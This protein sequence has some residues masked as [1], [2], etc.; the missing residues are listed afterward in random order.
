M[1]ETTTT[2]VVV[3]ADTEAIANTRSIEVESIQA[4]THDTNTEEEKEEIR[5]LTPHK[6]QVTN[7]N[8]SLRTDLLVLNEE[9]L[10]YSHEI[11]LLADTTPTK[12]APTSDDITVET[13]LLG[14]QD[15]L[16]DALSMGM[17]AEAL[18]T[19]VD[20]LALMDY[21]DNTDISVLEE[22]SVREQWAESTSG[23]GKEYMII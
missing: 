16:A 2:T 17:R 5:P 15:V 20:L 6:D 11:D 10:L 23:E 13:K 9:D 14:N 1:L 19:D 7:A 18:P 4:L 8:L 12:T 22:G 21:Y 3:Y